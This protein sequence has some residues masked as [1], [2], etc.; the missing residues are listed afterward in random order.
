M[1][2]TIELKSIEKDTIKQAKGAGFFRH[3]AG[4]IGASVS[5]TVSHSNLAQPSQSLI[6]SICY[7]HLYKVNTK[8]V[9]HGCKHEEDAIVTYE[10]EMKKYHV[11]FVLTR[12]GI[13]INK[14]QQ[15]IHA[16]PDFLTSCD[17][18]GLGC[19]EVKC[20]YSIENCDFES[21]VKKKTA[22]LEKLD[23][24]VFQLERHHN[25]YYQV[26]Q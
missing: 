23:N 25:Y 22:C 2:I 5:G 11:N 19:G 9:K 8:A 4:R 12:C 24:G 18:C 14:E 1:D 13:I 3:R 6:K 10:N 17:C 20:P 16:T 15:F 7:P 26:Q 21:Y